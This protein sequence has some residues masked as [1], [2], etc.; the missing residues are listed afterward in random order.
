MHGVALGEPRAGRRVLVDDLPVALVE[1]A[2]EAAAAHLALEAGALEA[3]EGD[4]QR[5]ADERGDGAALR[6]ARTVSV[7]SL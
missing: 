4:V 6:R 5:L 2:E 1:N 7:R 3:I